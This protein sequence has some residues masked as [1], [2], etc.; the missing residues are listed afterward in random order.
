MSIQ[1]IPSELCDYN[2]EDLRFTIEMSTLE[3]NCGPMKTEFAIK[4]KATGQLAPFRYL[5]KFYNFAGTEDV[6]LGGWVFEYAGSKTE[7][8]DLRV[9]VLND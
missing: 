5:R 7:L 4:S 8:W 9:V 2:K 6:E 3:G 1:I